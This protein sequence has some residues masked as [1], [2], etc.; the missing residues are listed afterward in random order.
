M[1]EE[2]LK[3]LNV[4][5]LLVSG[6]AYWLF[7]MVWMALFGKAWMNEVQE[8]GIKVE[9]PQRREMT[10]MM[11]GT[12]IYT[13]ITSFAISYLVFVV[14]TVNFAAAL[15]MGALLGTCIAF[16]SLGITYTW[17]KRSMKNLL[18]DGGYHAVGVTIATVILSLWQ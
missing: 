16:T 14:G 12:V 11:I 7:G 5:A 1:F 9:K 8:H 18:I 17:E 4:P 10:G 2:Y 15:K 6:L 3:H 13:M